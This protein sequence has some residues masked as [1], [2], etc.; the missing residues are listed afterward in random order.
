MKKKTCIVI[1]FLFC[2]ILSAQEPL[3]F[4][5]KQ[6]L[7][8][9]HIYDIQ[10]DTNGFMW[11]ATNRGLVKYNGET[12]RTFT[13][14][15]G[16]PNNDTWLLETDYQERLWYFSKSNYQGF[17]KNDSIYKFPVEDN[18]VI[19]PKFIHK[20]KQDLWL[21]SNG[22]YHILRNDT[23][24]KTFDNYL[25]TQIH[26]KVSNALLKKDVNF[27]DFLG[28]IHPETKEVIYFNNKCIWLLDANYQLTKKE[29]I[30]LPNTYKEYVINNFGVLYND[31]FY[32]GLENG[33][34]FVDFKT[35]TTKY[36]TFKELINV[37][38][39][40]YLRVKG[41]KD[42]IQVSIPGHLLTFN[43]N[44]EFKKS[45][46]FPKELGRISYRD[47]KGNIWLA[48][49]THGVSLIPN[50]QIKTSYFLQNKKVQKINKID[51]TFYV[52][53]NDD[54]FYQMNKSENKFNQFLKFK[55]GNGEIYQINK[56]D[57]GKT[58]FIST[59]NSYIK[60]NTTINDLV[61]NNKGLNIFSQTSI[62]NSIFFK[63]HNYNIVGSYVV[64]SDSDFNVVS[65]F[66]NKEGVLTST[67]FKN[68]LFY[69][70][71][72]GL[73]IV[74]NDTL[75][76]LKITH[77]LL[78]VSITNFLTT[79]ENLFVGTDGRGV[80]F[81]NDKDVVHLKN[82]DGFSVQKIIQKENKLWLATEKGVHQI[83][84]NKDD[85]E[86]SKIT[87]NFYTADGLLQNNTNDIYIEKDTLF[88]VSD[89]GI[90]KLNITDK[91]YAQKPNIYFKIKSDTLSYA[92]EKRDNISISFAALDYIN[93][94]NLSYQY[95]LLPTQKEW[96]TTT[97]K[98]LNFSNLSPELHQLQV[99]AT[100]Q[101]F[102]TTTV[103]QYVNVVPTWWQT[104]LAKIGFAVL[105]ILGFLGF[106]KILQKRIQAK[107]QAKAQLDKKIAGLELQA[108]RSQM[109]PHF[110]HNSLNAIQYYIQRNEVEHSENYLVKFS[111][112]V[113]LF[114][115]YSRKQ[116]ISI[117]E[118][119]S[120][121]NNYLEI[122]KLRFEDKLSY[123]IEV[124]KTIDIEEQ[125]IP[126]MM[127]QPIVE[128]AVNHGLFHK[129][130]NGLVTV[131][132]KKI[133]EKSF[134]VIVE[135]DGIGINKSKEMYKDSSKNYQS[136]SSA[137][138]EERL[139]LLQQ[140]NDW[141][142]EY[143]IQDLS[144]IS[145]KNGTRVTLIFNQPEL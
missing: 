26:K 66:S 82:T 126:S 91:I 83:T 43:Y 17:I 128:N 100:D 73:H 35:R 90:S 145:N 135:D 97:T 81:Y 142:I 112:L 24:Q 4:T 105:A 40:K 1:F 93:Q 31:I 16:L 72:D 77:N 20:S 75:T 39:I 113:R 45:Y 123:K 98:T 59:A 78:Q 102:N 64:K 22:G 106:A 60:K 86:N 114:F 34:L 49:F 23:L 103:S 32:Y 28:F 127:L 89:D 57:S 46:S 29:S 10:E 18:L 122:E 101:H 9:N 121:L 84:L 104:T 44:L 51:T 87:N 2:E 7:P 53:V 141:K 99:K 92:N 54:G 21:H 111:K 133:D 124:D 14:K 52:G 136:K 19:S 67:V 41:L 115:E 108:L 68:N 140:S 13:I 71:T 70:S 56:D 12:F 117:Q 120:L 62:K 119:I 15:D 69:G 27:N 130:E 5:T 38:S 125:I 116:N 42:E 132:F 36:I 76:T 6:G 50:T 48:D 131:L 47:S 95:R 107:E 110:V 137:V 8:S 96:K 79:K 80:Y 11:F 94:D 65:L 139:D 144:E 58:Y 30:S 143:T 118:E 25:F 109:N 3:R 134:T 88:A 74:K 85:L 37:E 138:L 129:K 63:N 33:V 61:L 55:N